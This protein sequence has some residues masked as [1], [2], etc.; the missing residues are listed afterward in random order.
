MENCEALRVQPAYPPLS[1][2]TLRME[3]ESEVVFGAGA[4]PVEKM[5]VLPTLRQIE[6]TIERSVLPAFRSDLGLL[7]A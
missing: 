7:T 1:K 2:D 3:S 4:G 6:E 5:S